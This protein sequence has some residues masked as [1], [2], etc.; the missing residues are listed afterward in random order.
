MRRME[1]IIPP[2]CEGKEVGWIL[3]RVLRLSKTK[4]KRAK[5]ASGGLLLDG[6]PVRSNQTV[7]AGQLL[8]VSIP[9]QEDSSTIVPTPG[10]VDIR[11]EDDWLLVV[12]KPAGLSVH[13][14]P[15]HYTD[16][17]GNYLTWHYRQQGKPF[18]LRLVNRLDKGTSGLL[19]AAK[20]AA[21]QEALMGQLHTDRFR[22]Q[23]LAICQGE[24]PER[25]DVIDLPIGKRPGA[26]NEYEVRPDGQGARTDYRVLEERNGR[27][28][29]SLTLHTG[30]THQIRVHLAALGCSLAGDALYGRGSP[31]DRPA[32]HSCKVELLH[33]ISGNLIS[34]ESPLPE[35]LNA[36]WAVAAELHH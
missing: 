5:F 22:R 4:V 21:V 33:P 24:P 7:R 29:L 20:S 6:Q 18:V 17:L 23:Y 34:V 14:G 13:P 36:F 28:L 27:C 8:Q 11:Y 12:E 10:P 32:L 35:D 16:T 31:P 3:R 1:L 30:R 19:V 25:E 26:L 15:G 9:E 2:E